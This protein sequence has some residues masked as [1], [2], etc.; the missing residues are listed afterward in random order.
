M[1]VSNHIE[2]FTDFIRSHGHDPEEPIIDDGILHAHVRDKQDRPGKKYLWYVLHGDGMP[3]GSFGHYAK[4]QE[5]ISWQAKAD[6]TLTSE[7]REQINKRS[8]ETQVAREKA[9]LEVR[10]ICCA[11]AEKMLASGRDVSANLDYIIA[12]NIIPY[13]A[14][15]LKDMLLIPLY[16]KKVLTG[17][18]IITK[19]SKKFLT[20]TDKKGAY[21]AINGSGKIVYLC[22]GWAD[23]CKIHELTGATVIVCFDC[24]NLLEVGKAIRAASG[25]NYE[26]VYVA[27]NDRF[28]KIHHEDGTV[29]LRPATPEENKGVTKATAA[30]LATGARLAIPTFPCDDGTDICDLSRISGNDAVM[31]CLESAV[32]VH[33]ETQDIEYKP[34]FQSFHE[35]M[36][37]VIEIKEL[38]GGIISGG[39]TCQLFGPSG[40]G[41]TF[42]ALDLGLSVASG[43]NWNGLPCKQGLVIYFNGEGR[44]GFKL[45]GKAWQKHHGIYGK[46]DFYASRTAISFDVQGIE[47]AIAE[48]KLIEQQTSQKVS[49]I[50]IDTLARHL[51][52]DENSTKDMSEFV[53]AVDNMRDT[54]TDSTA[55]IVHHTGNNAEVTG[56]SRGSS[57]LKAALD[58]EIQCMKGSL[59]FTKCKDIE[60]PAPIEFK[61]KVLEVGTKP[62]GT[63]ITS[64]VPVYGEKSTKNNTSETA[65]KMSKEELTIYQ[66]I[67]SHESGIHI[68]DARAAYIKH[69]TSFDSQIKLNSTYKSFTRNL[70]SLTLKNKISI[71]TNSIIKTDLVDMTGHFQQM[72]TL[73]TGQDWTLS[74]RSVQNVH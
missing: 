72:S 41:K 31:A 37:E 73:V 13:G 48:I 60:A 40:D 39:C 44:H 24:G 43:I 56:R 19:D 62:D 68:D 27:D 52:G 64:C 54:F 53:R 9:L 15:Q 38:I 45:R 66:I 55:L 71:D 21:L 17:L 57:A 61:L 12:H 46:V 18:Q 5:G 49:L 4:L 42:I 25:S 70:E 35:M 51:I 10:A 34:M 3:A 69:K 47:K 23:A 28:V 50:I 36:A 67:K 2:Q 7:Q 63:S 20:G 1:L 74:L 6:N 29:T 14:K 32:F 65:V 59:T 11:K 26:M 58:I 22:E 30:A 33:D 8:R 16:K